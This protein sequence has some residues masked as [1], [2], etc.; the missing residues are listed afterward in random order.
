[1]I[2]FGTDCVCLDTV[3]L[4]KEAALREVAKQLSDAGLV[5]PEYLEG[6]LA[7][8]EQT[9]TYLGNGIAIP[10]GTTTTRDQVLKTGIR[11]C[12]FAEGIDWGEGEKVYTAIGIAAKDNEHLALLQQLTRVIGDKQL[13]TTLNQTHDINDIVR[14]LRGEAAASALVFTQQQVRLNLPLANYSET[15]VTAG[16]LLRNSGAIDTDDL[17]AFYAIDPYYLNEGVWLVSQISETGKSA[18]AVVQT[19]SSFSLLDKPF[20]TLIA[21][22]ANDEA[23]WPF[24]NKLTQLRMSLGLKAL[25]QARQARD[26]LELLTIGPVTGS[27]IVSTV[28]NKE[29]L[30]ARPASNLV[31]IAKQYDIDIW[32]ENVSTQSLPVNARSVT[33]LIGLGAQLGHQLKT[34]ANGERC[35]RAIREI[36]QAIAGGLGDNVVEEAVIPDE[37]LPDF[38]T[39]VNETFDPPIE[40]KQPKAGDVIA[41]LCGASGIAFGKASIS[42]EPNF[43]FE[44][45]STAP[46]EQTLKRLTDAISA[47]K[48]I[49][50]NKLK[51]TMLS[52]L[53]E[54]LTMH[55]ELLD[56]PEILADATHFIDE[57]A[58]AESGWQ[59]SID[60]LVVSQRN[61]S[62]ELFA[63][64]AI[65][66]RDIGNSVLAQLTGHRPLHNNNEAHI[67]ICEDIAPSHMAEMDSAEVL[68][69]VCAGGGTTSHSAILARSLGIPLLVACTEQVLHIQ[70]DTPLI[71]DCDRGQLTIAPSDATIASA[72]L[73]KA[74][75]T[76]RKD[77][78]MESRFQPATTID[79]HTV[80]VV[81][82]LT[83]SHK[84]AE[85]V[86]QGADGVGLLRTEFIYMEHSQEPSVEIQRQRYKEVLD[87]LD[88]KPLVI[89]TMDVGGDKPLPYLPMPKE[90]NPFLGI[91]GVRLSLL[92]PQMLSRQLHAILQALPPILPPVLPPILPQA[93]DH[94]ALRIMFPM[95]ADINEWRAVTKI[96]R[97]VADQ[98]PDVIVEL[99][100]MI[101]VPSAALLADVFAKEVDFFS[102]G[103]N[104]LTQYCYAIDRGHPQLSSQADPMGPAVLRLIDHTVKA[105]NRS[106]IW[107]GVCGE[108]AGNPLGAAILTGLGVRE[109][110]MSP[111]SIALIKSE[112]RALTLTD[113]N[114]LARQALECENAEAVHKLLDALPSHQG[115]SF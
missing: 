79:G 111:T 101:E 69:V 11:L 87:A 31:K 72:R 13:A 89:R 90:D 4:D 80:D 92:K 39:P 49:L 45:H 53:T 5:T 48:Q 10:H 83:S 32:I 96:Y 37:P 16:A 2:E 74:R 63:Q 112:L 41:G 70:P 104:D 46:V 33:K 115:E 82:N 58:S 66:I 28:V 34:T 113:A 47:V 56:D 24:L 43:Q 105:A 77:A 73:A 107:V 26:V 97:Q 86:E 102:I 64:R 57:G 81:A 78:A 62:S 42:H 27:S 55:Q 109:L 40:I 67:L 18:A 91:R 14:I 3:A 114:A 108:L 9:S 103:T 71:V 88:G 17:P 1:M 98:Y 22:I 84:A 61:S 44:T 99:G 76:Q 50:D 30:H 19:Q 7:R 15:V 106:G 21:V 38:P 75:A 36:A 6:M 65:D 54:I 110:S 23:H 52:E 20:S 25:V 60:A 8:E 93:T 12:R 35:E 100:M 59:Q 29:G 51:K 95:I 68:A 85:A 94:T